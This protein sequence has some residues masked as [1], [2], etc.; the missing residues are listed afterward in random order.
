M[1]ILQQGH[2]L[3]KHYEI[4]RA[5]HVSG[6]SVVYEAHDV[7]SPES[8]HVAVKEVLLDTVESGPI[9]DTIQRLEAKVML[10]K[11]LDHPAIPATL[12]HF[13]IQDR[14]Y[15]ITDFIP[16]KDLETILSETEGHLDIERVCRWGITLADALHYLHN[17]E[18]EPIIY[19]DLKPS[20]IMANG[21]DRVSLIDFGIS[22]TFPHGLTLEPLGTD[23][24]AA[25][26]QYS[27]AATPAIDIFSLG[28]TL[29]HLLTKCDPRLESPFTFDERPIKE[30]N[31]DVPEELVEIVNRALQEK[32][33]ERFSNASEMCEAL[34]AIY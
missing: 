25:P 32:P 3:H 18:P 21:D 15:L 7:Q 8:R 16:G 2:R 5:V 12:A 27:G 11:L 24:Y 10:L 31:P 13:I 34:A 20:N 6:L 19:R 26:E 30:F 4:I 33:G 1:N 14:S 29:H 17:F 23:G 22:D 9:E 28:A